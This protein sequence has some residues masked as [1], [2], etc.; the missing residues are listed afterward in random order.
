MRCSG[1]RRIVLRTLLAARGNSLA[2]GH[3]SQED[4]WRRQGYTLQ[5]SQ[6]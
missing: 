4:K 3:L 6:A 2:D 1:A 5:P